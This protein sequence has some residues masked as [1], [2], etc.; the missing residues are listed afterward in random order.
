MAKDPQHTDTPLQVT[1][2]HG[3][4]ARLLV[5]NVVPPRPDGLGAR[6]GR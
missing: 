4:S 2:E 1:G 3:P 6:R 5:R